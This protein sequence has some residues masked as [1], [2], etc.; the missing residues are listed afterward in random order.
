M[1]TETM[2]KKKVKHPPMVMKQDDV[3]YRRRLLGRWDYLCIVCGREFANIACVTKEHIIPRCAK[4]NT[5]T[6]NLA[7]S[8]HQCNKLRGSGSILHAAKLIED[9]AAS[10]RRD[11]FVRWLNAPVPNRVVPQDALKPL[12][13]MRCLELPENLPGMP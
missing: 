2:A 12:R 10:M 11:R 3:N 1:Y 9:K 5:V 4:D 8:H 6:D 13:A 7:P